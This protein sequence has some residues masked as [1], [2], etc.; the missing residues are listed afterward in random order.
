MRTV[1]CGT[2]IHEYLSGD[3]KISEIHIKHCT[4]DSYCYSFNGFVLLQEG[5]SDGGSSEE[6]GERTNI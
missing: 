1:R 4:C 2:S 5:K 3:F 6:K